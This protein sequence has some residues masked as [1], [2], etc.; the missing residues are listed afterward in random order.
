MSKIKFLIVLVGIIGLVFI[1]LKSI[2]IPTVKTEPIETASSSTTPTVSAIQP[3][4]SI[5]ALSQARDDLRAIDE[6]N[7]KQEL[8]MYFADKQSYPSTLEELT[9][10]YLRTRLVD[11]KTKLPYQYSILQKGGDYQL[12]INFE[13]K[14][15]HCSSS[16]Q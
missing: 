12:C 11:P 3:F 15:T 5:K 4:S 8:T 2:S 6:R 14:A 9:P 7:I 13:N 16:N 1:A 10:S